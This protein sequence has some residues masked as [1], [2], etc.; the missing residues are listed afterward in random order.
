MGRKRIAWD[1]L[2]R[3]FFLEEVAMNEDCA[4]FADSLITDV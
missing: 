4:E 2:I 1:F 3:T